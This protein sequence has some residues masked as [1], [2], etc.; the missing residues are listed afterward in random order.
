MTDTS[1]RAC[2]KKQKTSQTYKEKYNDGGLHST[3]ES[4]Q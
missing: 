1:C 2:Q 4:P 3:A